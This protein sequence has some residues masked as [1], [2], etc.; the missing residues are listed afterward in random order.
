MLQ[1]VPIDQMDHELLVDVFSASCLVVGYLCGWL[2][3]PPPVNE[4]LVSALRAE[5]DILYDRLNECSHE[6]AVA[7]TKGLDEDVQRTI[8]HLVDVDGFERARVYHHDKEKT[9]RDLQWEVIVLVIL[10]KKA[11]DKLGL[12]RQMARHSAILEEEQEQLMAQHPDL[13]AEEV[14]Q[15]MMATSPAY[16]EAFELSTT[17]LARLQ[18]VDVEAL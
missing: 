12:T 3:E 15:L 6:E 17:L 11:Q 10:Q 9:G 1:P 18:A 7:F 16:R 5:R 4:A 8:R 2:P 13:T 14:Q